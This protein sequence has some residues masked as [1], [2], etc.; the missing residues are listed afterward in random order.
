MRT[1]TITATAVT[2]LLGAAIALAAPAA[3]NQANAP[4]GRVNHDQISLRRDGDRAVPFDPVVGP[5]GKLVLRRVGSKAEPF[6]AEIGN[7]YV[8]GIESDGESTTKRILTGYALDPVNNLVNEF[9]PDVAKRIHVRIIF[10]QQILNNIAVS[11]N[12]VM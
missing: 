1:T 4:T 9:L 6:V 7:L 12:G 3:A 5:G 10:V 11:G 2:I 8:P